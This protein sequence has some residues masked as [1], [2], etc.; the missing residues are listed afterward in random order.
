MSK[1]ENTNVIPSDHSLEQYEQGARN[2]T[3]EYVKKSIKRMKAQGSKVKNVKNQYLAVH[4]K[5]RRKVSR[6]AR[7][8]I[9]EP[10][11]F[12][13]RGTQRAG[14]CSLARS[15]I[16]SHPERALGRFSGR[17]DQ[18]KRKVE[19]FASGFVRFNVFDCK[20]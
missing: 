2:N 3:S 5:P 11:Y 1:G 7:K 19:D 6:Y 4:E 14:P 9:E 18:L 17:G 13:P 20:I 10:D 8:L 16:I 12:G 15:S